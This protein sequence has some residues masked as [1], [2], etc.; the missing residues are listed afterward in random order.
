MFTILSVNFMCVRETVFEYFDANEINKTKV[1]AKKS[2]L[3]FVFK[4]DRPF[5]PHPFWLSFGL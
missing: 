5:D 4:S 1:N 3:M 2:C